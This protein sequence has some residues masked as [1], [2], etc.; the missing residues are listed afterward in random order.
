MGCIGVTFLQVG[1]DGGFDMIRV[2]ESSGRLIRV[3]KE[4]LRVMPSAEEFQKRIDERAERTDLSLAEV[5][6]LVH[7]ARATED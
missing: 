5:T 1:V 6:D 3:R 2:R 7:D 4:I